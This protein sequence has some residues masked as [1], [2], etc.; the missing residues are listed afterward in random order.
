M[1]RNARKALPVSAPSKGKESEWA[2]KV[3]IALQVRESSA[4][5][6]KGKPMS[7]PTGLRRRSSAQSKAP[8]ST[9]SI[10]SGTTGNS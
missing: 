10:R 8:S 5:A 9:R 7:F 1:H 3:E 4:E 6:R 2:A